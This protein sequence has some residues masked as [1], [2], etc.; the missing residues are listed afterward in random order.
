MNHAGIPRDRTLRKMDKDGWDAVLRTNLDSMFNVTRPFIW[1]PAP[2]SRVGPTSWVPDLE[3]GNMLAKQI[4]YMGH[5]DST[6]IVTG[7]RVP[8]V[9]TSGAH[10]RQ[11]R[12]ASSAIALMLAPRYRVAPP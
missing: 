2:K 7:A 12:L 11:T 10:S 8:V 1:P 3:S 4:E 9:L 5:A 6:G